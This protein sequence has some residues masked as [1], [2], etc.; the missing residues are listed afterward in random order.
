MNIRIYEMR[1]SGMGPFRDTQIIKLDGRTSFLYAPNGH[2]KTGMID[3]IRWCL[4]GE[5]AIQD[6]KSLNL[7]L[8]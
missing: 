5:E 4:A 7:N 6:F 8:C 2:G 3:L 1:I